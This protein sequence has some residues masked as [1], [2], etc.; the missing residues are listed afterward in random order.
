[1]IDI[2]SNQK[3]Q[4]AFEMAKKARRKAYAKYSRHHVSSALKCKG[5]D[6]LFLGV[7]L[8]NVSNGASICAER[9]AFGA[10]R[11]KLGSFKPEFIV[12]LSPS[13]VVSCGM[14]LQVMAE[15]VKPDFVIY[16]GTDAGLQ[17][18]YKFSDLMHQAF[19]EF[20]QD[21]FESL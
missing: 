7:N 13:G 17:K 1:M 6:E 4:T 18:Q 8:E 20:Q 2:S 19:T 16:T 21:D 9:N 3:L 14:C 10:A 12:I 5:V 15:F 11:V